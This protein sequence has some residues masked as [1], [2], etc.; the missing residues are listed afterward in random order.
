[1]RL[2]AFWGLLSGQTSDGRL[3]LGCYPHRF[4]RGFSGLSVDAD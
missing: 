3:G 1:M 4:G 2:A